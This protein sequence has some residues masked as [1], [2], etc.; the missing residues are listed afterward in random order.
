MP[1]PRWVNPPRLRSTDREP[2][3]RHATW[4]EL[5]FDLV[6]VVAVAQ[7]SHLISNDPS[8]TSF[9]HYTLLFAPV[10]FIWVGFTVYADRFDT[11]DVPHRLLVLAG[12][13][14]I[15]ALAVHVDDAFSGGSIPFALC[16][17]LARAILLAMNVRAMRAVPAARDYIAVYVR[18]WSAGL[19]LWIVSL[20]VP[21]P[22]RYIVWGAAVLIEVAT[23][24]VAERRVGTVALHVSHIGERFALFTIIVLGESVVSVTAGIAEVDFDLANSVIAVGAFVT[25]SALAWVYFDRLG[26]ELI[27]S[28][29]YVYA[30]F[31]V[32]LGLAAV[33]PGT[34]LAIEAADDSALPAGARAALCGGA[35]LYLLGLCLVAAPTRRSEDGRRR[36]AARCATAG[37]AV[38]I[39]F[40]GAAIAPVATVLLL[41][42]VT[43]ADLVYELV[44]TGEGDERAV[45]PLD[46]PEGV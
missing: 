37:A 46:L 33:G 43:V 18:G 10:W 42:A 35:A 5:F 23:P 30:H 32:Y 27:G 26:T 14:V 28:T 1:D 16:S 45:S 44:A 17:I 21:E 22:G 6:F 7:L 34:L 2:G 15:A 20:A 31:V 39:A 24:L 29:L 38:A 19:L 41:A 9:L 13:A 11:D 25:A 36:I 12:M 8:A 4:V 40:L 3:E